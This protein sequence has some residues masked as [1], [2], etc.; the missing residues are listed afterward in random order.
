MFKKM[1]VLAMALG[2]LAAFALPMSASGAWTHEH[3]PIV[4]NKQIA[5]TGQ[6]FFHATG[7]GIQGGIRCQV[8]STAQFYG[9]G[10]TTGQIDTF[11]I[12]PG[13]TVTNRCAGTGG[14]ALCQQHQ[15]QPTEVGGTSWTIHTNQTNKTVEITT[16]LIHAEVT[17]AFCPFTNLT[18]TPLTAVGTPDNVNTTS[19]LTLSGNATVDIPGALPSH[20]GG[21]LHIEAPNAGTYGI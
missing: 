5:L 14:L 13:S 6:V 9:V 2:A 18:V 3:K 15:F 1:T 11:E 20:I 12:D 16:K 21:T 17:G 4:G 10:S 19:T 8:T 7:G